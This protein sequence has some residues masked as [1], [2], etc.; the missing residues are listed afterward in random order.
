MPIKDNVDAK[1]AKLLKDIDEP[2]CANANTD[3]EDPS[4]A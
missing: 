4:R 2:K 3:T 1:R